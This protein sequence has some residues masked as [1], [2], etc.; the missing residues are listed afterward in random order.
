MAAQVECGWV[1]RMLGCD[2]DAAHITRSRALDQHDRVSTNVCVCAD[3]AAWVH[4]CV[5]VC[6][7]SHADSK[8]LTRK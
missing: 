8:E 7:C 5:R 2:E 4:A 3:A 6:V 1:V